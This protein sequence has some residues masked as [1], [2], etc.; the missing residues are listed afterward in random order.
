MRIAWS[1]LLVLLVAGCAGRSTRPAVDNKAALGGCGVILQNSG[2]DPAG[3]DCRIYS[4]L[5][6]DEV[7]GSIGDDSGLRNAMHRAERYTLCTYHPK[8]GPV[9]G[10]SGYILLNESSNEVVYRRS[11]R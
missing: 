10:G 11:G 2:I 3:K 8:V 5:T 4:G 1:M 9:L 7:V 6:M